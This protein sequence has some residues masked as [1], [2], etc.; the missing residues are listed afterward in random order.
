MQNKEEEKIKEEEKDKKEETVVEAHGTSK[1]QKSMYL[2]SSLQEKILTHD[3][4]PANST[5][6]YSK[7]AEQGQIC[8]NHAKCIHEKKKQ[9]SRLNIDEQYL[10][11]PESSL[12]NS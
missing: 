11:T 6:I 5:R 3:G 7:P 4:I 9:R 10:T 2:H 1:S 12:R 8:Q